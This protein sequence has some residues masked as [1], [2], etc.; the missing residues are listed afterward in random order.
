MGLWQLSH[1]LSSNPLSQCKIVKL[2]LKLSK[3]Y[4]AVQL[5]WGSSNRWGDCF[6][7]FETMGYFGPNSGFRNDGLWADRFTHYTPYK[8]LAPK[9]W[10][11]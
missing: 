8:P 1:C 2:P 9:S 11:Q 5:R 7:P 6:K 3:Y 4:A 10:F